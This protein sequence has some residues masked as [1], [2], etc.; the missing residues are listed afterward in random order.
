[1]N[2]S[3]QTSPD[4]AA[5][6]TTSNGGV[7]TKEEIAASQASRHTKKAIALNLIK[8]GNFTLR[9]IA[10]MAYVSLATVGR[11]NAL[12]KANP[13]LSEAD[14]VERKRGPDPDPF[15][16]VSWS[17]CIAIQFIVHMCFP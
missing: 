9:Q 5:P 4:N 11:I 13:N 2:S 12:Y 16:V 3:S 8:T 17:V 6:H 1:M 14:L 10:M 7:K 15:K